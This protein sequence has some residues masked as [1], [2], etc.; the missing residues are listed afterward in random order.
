MPPAR[1]F[2]DD[3]KWS[4]GT[5]DLIVSSPVHLLKAT[6][7]DWYGLLA[8]SPTGLTEDR[9]VQAVEIKEVR[10]KESPIKRSSGDLS[11]FIVHHASISA[12]ERLP[13]DAGSSRKQEP[14]PDPTGTTWRQRHLQHHP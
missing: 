9:Y 7:A 12:R 13:D 8:P 11:L 5:P 14:A 10:L 2:T 1:V 6:A 3:S 4:F